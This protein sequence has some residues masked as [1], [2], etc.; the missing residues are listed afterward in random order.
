LLEVDEDEE[1]VDAIANQLE[2]QKE[3]S[4]HSLPQSLDTL[5]PN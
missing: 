5:P 4:F 2:V 1:G 3:D